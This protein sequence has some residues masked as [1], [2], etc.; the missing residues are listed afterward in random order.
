MRSDDDDPRIFIIIPFTA[1]VKIKSIAILGL[2][3]STVPMQMDAYLVILYR[4]VNREDI[5]FGNV[6]NNLPTQQW[7]LVE[8]SGMGIVPEYPTKLRLF[9][10]VRSLTLVITGAASS[11][12][13]QI[14]Y[15]GFKGE[16]VHLVKDTIITNYEIAS[17][18]TDH[19]LEWKSSIGQV[20][21]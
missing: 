6:A 3:D 9:S 1:V 20:E 4:F 19:K 17:N 2:N 10:N 21:F 7:D 13:L 14:K 16:F 11:E 12:F 8:R 15:A 18:P 5:D